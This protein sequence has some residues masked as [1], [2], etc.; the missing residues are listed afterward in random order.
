MFD[1]SYETIRKTFPTT[2]ATKKRKPN[3]KILSVMANVLKS[4][5]KQEEWQD[6]FS[7]L[8]SVLNPLDSE[9]AAESLS[10]HPPKKIRL[11]EETAKSVDVTNTLYKFKGNDGDT[12]SL[13]AI[14]AYETEGNRE[15]ISE[16]TPGEKK[17]LLHKVV[18]STKPFLYL[19]DDFVEENFAEIFE[20]LLVYLQKRQIINVE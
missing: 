12:L 14:L 19:N 18:K 4:N 13:C 7:N 17:R 3:T 11:V 9:I 15:M 8:D 6:K 5:I 20:H 10:F 2:K 1:V 16:M